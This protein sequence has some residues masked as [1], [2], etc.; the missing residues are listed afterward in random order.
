VLTICEG[1][2]G[3]GGGNA[4]WFLDLMCRIDGVP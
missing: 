4:V 1:W 3:I 2:D